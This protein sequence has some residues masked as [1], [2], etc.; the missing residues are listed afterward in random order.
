MK[1]GA[2][3]K[4]SRALTLAIAVP[5]GHRLEP[6]DPG[7]LGLGRRVRRLQHHRVEDA[8]EVRP[9]HPRRTHPAAQRVVRSPYVVGRLADAQSLGPHGAEERDRIPCPARKTDCKSFNRSRGPR[10]L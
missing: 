10:G 8:V 2:L 6:L 3:R 9:D 4:R 1:G 5:A 7:V